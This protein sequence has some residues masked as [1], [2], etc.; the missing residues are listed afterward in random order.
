MARGGKLLSAPLA[1]KAPRVLDIGCGSGIWA[2]QM[3]DEHPEASIVG[4]DV[5]PIQPKKY[6]CLPLPLRSVAAA[7][8]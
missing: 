6:V 3:A 4:M 8:K 5:S 1:V 7:P 2:I